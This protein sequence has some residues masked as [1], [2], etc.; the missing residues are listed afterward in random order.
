ML[1]RVVILADE[2]AHWKIA[3][4]RQLERVALEATVPDE[5]MELCVLWRPDFPQE[6]RFRPEHPRLSHFE[7]TTDRPVS[8]DLLL[9]THL[10]LQRNVIPSQFPAGPKPDDLQRSFAE[11]L[12][13]VRAAWQTATPN[14]GWEYLE[15]GA[16]IDACEIHF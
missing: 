12:A 2:S 7:I 9:S 11:L 1:R 16:Q 3:G 14:E 8:A 6:Q 4:L 10:F 15:N 13:A 5:R